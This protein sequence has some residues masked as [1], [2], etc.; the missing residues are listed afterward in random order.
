MPQETKEQFISRLMD[1]PQMVAEF[2]EQKQRQMVAEAKWENKSS[3]IEFKSTGGLEVKDLNTNRRTAVIAHAVYDVMDR[4]YP[5]PDISR[6]GMFNKSWHESKARGIEDTMGFYIN[7]DPLKQPGLVK[8]VWE[9]ENKAYTKVWFGNHTLGN[10]TMLMMDEGIIRDASFSFKAIKKDIRE[11][12]GKK[13]RELKEVLQGETS[14]VIGIPPVNPLA[15]VVSVSKAMTPESILKEFKS[16]IDRMESFARNTK[17]S[18][19]TIININNEIKTAREFISS[20]DT[21]HT[22][23]NLEPSASV[24]DFSNALRLYSLRV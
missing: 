12:K 11:I 13:V 4:A 2:P 24:V 7:H 16:Y 19:E 15:G 3:D 10:D 8:D 9:T 18:D 17:A 20:Y 6:K 22:Q 23:E 14:V 21:A 1:D 5:I